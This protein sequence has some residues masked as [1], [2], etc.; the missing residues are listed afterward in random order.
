MMPP[1][2]VNANNSWPADV[3]SMSQNVNLASKIDIVPIYTQNY[4]LPP[5][6]A[7]SGK[8]HVAYVA[9]DFDATFELGVTSGK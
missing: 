6:V 1:V 4:V 7:G 5:R 3:I 9:A 8:G 2:N